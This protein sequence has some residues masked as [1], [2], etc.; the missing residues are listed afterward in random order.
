MPGNTLTAVLWPRA[1]HRG[2]CQ[3]QSWVPP[4][5]GP[6]GPP[7]EVDKGAEQE[8]HGRQRSHIAPFC[9]VTQKHVASV[10]FFQKF[11]DFDFQKLFFLFEDEMAIFFS[12][13]SQP[14]STC[15]STLSCLYPVDP[16]PPPPC[17]LQLWTH[18]GQHRGHELAASECIK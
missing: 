6:G 15:H 5:Q 10:T 12:Q 16:A 1:H 13:R 2:R 7:K 3:S 8:G 18:C 9:H 4:T 17:P 11:F 14:E